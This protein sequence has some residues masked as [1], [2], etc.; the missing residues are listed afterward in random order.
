MRGL[1][2]SVSAY[3]AF[4]EDCVQERASLMG[5]IEAIENKMLAPGIPIEIPEAME[6]KVKAT[7][8]AFEQAV[9]QDPKS[10]MAIG[11]ALAGPVTAYQ[12]DWNILPLGQQMALMHLGTYKQFPPLQIAA[13]YNLDAV[14]EQLRASGHPSE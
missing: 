3:A 13:S 2:V 1:S 14:M 7:L 10:S 12:Y 9:A 4:I 5:L 8:A 11:G 6:A